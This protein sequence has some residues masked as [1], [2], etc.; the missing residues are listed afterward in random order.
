MVL[1]F[2]LNFGDIAVGDQGPEPLMQ[3][4]LAD[5][6][7]VPFPV[8]AEVNEQVR[9]QASPTSVNAPS[10]QAVPQD[11]PAL[12]NDDVRFWEAKGCGWRRVR[13]KLRT[14]TPCFKN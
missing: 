1:K 4:D 14:L 3:H 6:S 13:E 2:G 12:S 7:A 5:L 11:K 8:L 9:R 10:V